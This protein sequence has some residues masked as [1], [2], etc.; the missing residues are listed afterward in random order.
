[1]SDEHEHRMH[2]IAEPY[3]EAAVTA[4][5]L[6]AAEAVCKDVE[7]MIDVGHLPPQ[8]QLVEGLAAWRAVGGGEEA[9]LR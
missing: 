6:A 8:P 7:L 5:R 3:G 1:M 2:Q 4:T 9:L